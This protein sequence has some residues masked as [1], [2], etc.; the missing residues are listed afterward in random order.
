MLVKFNGHLAAAVHQILLLALLVSPVSAV[1]SDKDDWTFNV[2]PY[3]WVT[4]QKGQ[5]ATLPPAA[6]A[7][8]DVSFSDVISN[9]DMALM[10]LVEARNGRFG[11]FGE[12]FYVG[13]SADADTPGPFFSGAD[14]EQ[15]LLGISIGLSYALMQS[16]DHHLDAVLGVRFWDLD[17]ELELGAGILPARKLSEHERWHDPFIGL[18]GRVNLNENWYLSGW[19]V[20]AVAGDSDSSWDL[21]GGIGYEYSDSFSLTAG[22]RHQEVDYKND[23]FLFDV[24]MSGPVIGLTFRF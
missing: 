24:E 5:V 16:S 14:Y 20:A 21:F 15:D 22:Y 1:A 2:T 12:I 4:G 18:K 3:L 13:V 23:G 6:P 10:G 11:V 9:L 7:D 8:L 17:N 19:G